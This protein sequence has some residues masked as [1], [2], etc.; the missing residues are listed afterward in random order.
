MKFKMDVLLKLFRRIGVRELMVVQDQ[1]VEIPE[2]GQMFRGAW[3]IIDEF[4]RADIDKAFGQL[5]TALRT[6]TLKIPTDVEGKSYKTLKIPEDYRIIGTLN[7]L[8][9]IIC[10]SCQMHSKAD[11]PILKLIFQRKN[12]LSRKSTMP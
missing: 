3:L 8:T 2:K 4:N 11:L 9:N 7:T 10:S 6:R 12:N 5:F 1:M